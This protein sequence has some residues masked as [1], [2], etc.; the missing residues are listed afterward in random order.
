MRA[1]RAII[2]EL[3]GEHSATQVPMGR[4]RGSKRSGTSATVSVIHIDGSASARGEA[5]P[6]VAFPTR[7]AIKTDPRPNVGGVSFGADGV[8]G[9]SRGLRDSPPTDVAGREPWQV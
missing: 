3:G 8:T 9:R 7:P 6:I 4:A 2:P 5:P 1:D